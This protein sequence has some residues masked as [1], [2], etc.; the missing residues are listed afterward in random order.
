MRAAE[1]LRRSLGIVASYTLTAML[2]A[3]THL[4]PVSLT[5][6]APGSPGLVVFDIDGT[7]TPAVSRIF[8]VRPDASYV[9]RLYAQRGYRILYLTAR[10]PGLQGNLRRYLS[11][12]AFPSGDLVAPSTRT[13]HRSPAT[14]K[15]SVLERYR[16]YGWN[17]AAAYGDS[18]SDFEAYA[19]A[20][21]PRARVFALRRAGASRCRPGVWAACLPGW[22]PR[23]EELQESSRQDP[24]TTERS[25]APLR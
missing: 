25:P 11:R 1:R 9:A 13:E 5:Q 10:A 3:C 21:V 6:A 17:I 24:S 4:P 8:S 23:R 2:S 14:F 12:Y 16:R 18:S 20:G 7:L 15:A 19:A 22:E